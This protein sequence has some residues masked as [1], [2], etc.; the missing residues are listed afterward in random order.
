MAEQESVGRELVKVVGFIIGHIGG[1]CRHVRS[2][3]QDD[4]QDRCWRDC[5]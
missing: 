4:D 2:R 3:R 1:H 5:P